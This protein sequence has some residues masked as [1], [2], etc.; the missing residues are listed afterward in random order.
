MFCV[1]KVVRFVK[2]SIL[3]VEMVNCMVLDCR[4]MLM[5]EVMIRL[6]MFIIR[7]VFMFDRF[8]LVV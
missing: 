2:I 7:K 5:I 6:I 3:I 4:K 1:L 8:F